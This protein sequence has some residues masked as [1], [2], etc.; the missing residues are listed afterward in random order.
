[1]YDW[2]REDF[3]NHVGYLPQGVELFSGTIKQNIAKMSEE[4]DPEKV[5]DAALMAGAHDL[6]LKFPNGYETDI[7][8]GGSSLSGGQK[9]RIGLARAFYGNPKFIVLDEPNANL[10]EVGELALSNALQLAKQKGI[11]VVVI[12]H[13]PSVLSVVDKIL[14]LQNGTVAVFGDREEVMNQLNNHK[15]SIHK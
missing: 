14:V 12:S 13:R 3:G 9:Q 11:T 8:I 6:I 1:M 2:N 4:I 5:T 15:R 7:G 10:D